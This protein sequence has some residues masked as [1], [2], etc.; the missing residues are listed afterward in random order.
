MRLDD[1]E[2]SKGRGGVACIGLERVECTTEDARGANTHQE[3]D[4]LLH[5]PHV[6][7]WRCSLLWRVQL[8]SLSFFH[9]SPTTPSVFP[10]P[11]PNGGPDR[12]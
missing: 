1:G 4:P 9:S 12:G 3:P 5:L 11:S 8:Q 2:G 10:P 6:A 7:A